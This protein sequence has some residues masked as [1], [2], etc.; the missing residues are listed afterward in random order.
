MAQEAGAGVGSVEEVTVDADLGASREGSR[1][2]NYSPTIIG[3]A[4]YGLFT[5]VCSCVGIHS[6]VDFISY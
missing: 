3:F 2:G 4:R 5:L 6:S 1:T